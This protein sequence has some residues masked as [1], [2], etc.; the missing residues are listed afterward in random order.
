MNPRHAA[1]LGTIA[2]AVAS[3]IAAC[4]PIEHHTDKQ[5][6]MARMTFSPEKCEQVGAVYYQ[7]SGE[8]TLP[9]ASEGGTAWMPIYWG[10]TSVPRF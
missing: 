8:H 10:H 3:T 5:A 1:A 2:L 4:T 6:A 9:G 7:C